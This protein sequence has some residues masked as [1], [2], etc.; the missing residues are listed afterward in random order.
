M[1][2]VPLEVGGGGRAAGLRGD[3]RKL[4]LKHGLS[5]EPVPVSAYVGSW[6][7]LTDLKDA[8]SVCTGVS[9]P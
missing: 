5:T 6:K 3:E 8:T 7:D 1:S 2:E 4:S 9:R